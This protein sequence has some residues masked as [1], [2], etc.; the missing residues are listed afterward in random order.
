MNILMIS[1]VYFPRINGVSTSIQTFKSE[2]EKQGHH[3]SLIAP[4]Y[5]GSSQEKNIFRIPSRNIPYDPEDKMMS[6]KAITRLLPDLEKLHF[7]LIHIHTPFVAHYAGVNLSKA[8]KIPCI[9]TYHTLFEEYLYH[10]VPIVPKQIMRFFTRKFS[11]SQNDQV[12]G[13]IAP[14]SVIV[15][16]LKEYGVHNNITIIPTGIESKRFE[17]GDGNRFITK[18][19]IPTDKKIL[20]N[21]SRVAYEKNMGVL[22]EMLHEVKKAIPEIFL[23]IAGEGP[24]KKSYMDQASKLNLDDNIAFVGYLDR[25]TELI[26]C[27][28]CADIFVF[29]SKTETQGLVLLEAM[30]C[31]I[32]VVSVAEMGTKD[33]LNNCKAAKIT[34]G[35]VSDFSEKV[36][37]LLGSKS[38]YDSL[39]SE[40]KEYAR[41]WDS[42]AIAKK[43]LEFYKEII[44]SN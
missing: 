29:S 35:E 13:V 32:P 8:L 17:K 43:M 22:I 10:Y 12:Q 5:E 7:D 24:A 44:N 23:I 33:V 2:F 9:A 39:K 14:S 31:G 40:A 21:V 42:A 27:Y 34:T 6:Y 25:D 3:V 28:Y 19:N 30:A 1:D 36:I 4:T 26:D 38:E 20:L 15:N 16:L 41:E 18:H 37:S 11:S